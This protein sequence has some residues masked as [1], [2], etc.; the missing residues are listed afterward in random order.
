MWIS[1]RMFIQKGLRKEYIKKFHDS[2]NMGHPGINKTWELLSRK[3]HF[4]GMRTMI[5]KSLEECVPCRMN[6]KTREKQHG[7]LQPIGTPNRSW[8]VI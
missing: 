7:L 3:H 8:E 2:P 4:S 5:T 6:K 1:N